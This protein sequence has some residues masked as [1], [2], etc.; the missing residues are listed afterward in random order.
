MRLKVVKGNEPIVPHMILRA[1]ATDGSGADAPQVGHYLRGWTFTSMETKVLAKFGSGSMKEVK[2]A[3]LQ[4]I[5]ITVSPKGGGVDPR[6]QV[7]IDWLKNIIKLAQKNLL[8]VSRAR[9]N[10]T[11]ARP[12]EEP[13]KRDA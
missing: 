9:I 12:H 4:A 2:T 10:L 8:T 13:V 7:L 1:L 3:D 5:G 11:A 6:Q